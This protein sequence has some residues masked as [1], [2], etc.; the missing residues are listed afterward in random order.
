MRGVL[1][2]ALGLLAAPALAAEGHRLGVAEPMSREEAEALAAELGL[3]EVRVYR[4]FLPG[5]GWSHTVEVGPLGDAQAAAGIARELEARGLE[6]WRSGPEAGSPGEE[7]G[8][9]L[10]RPAPLAEPPR[11]VEGREAA[12]SVVRDRKA[13]A[14]LRGAARLHQGTLDGAA[15]EDA[16]ALDFRFVRELQGPQGSLRVRHSYAREGRARALEVEVLEGAGTSSRSIITPGNRAV[17]LA[18]GSATERDPARLLEIVERFSPEGVL[19]H[20]LDLPV[21]LREGSAW[22]GLMLEEDTEVPVLR[23]QVERDH[24]VLHARFEG[25]SGLLAELTLADEGGAR[26]WLLEEWGET[27]A[28]VLLPHRVEVYDGETLLERVW[29]EALELGEAA[30]AGTFDLPDVVGP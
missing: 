26:T 13:E 27:A 17:L 16:R 7:A 9:A 22:R 14:W 30:P 5:S 18:G 6:I 23:P 10:P 12:I 24:G 15:L 29:V 19:G 20:V 1:L 28:G 3:P 21:E 25:E 11:A 4:R 2:L 8:P